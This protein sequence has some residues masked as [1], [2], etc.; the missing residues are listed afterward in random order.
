M[1]HRPDGGGQG[2]HSLSIDGVSVSAPATVATV[3]EPSLAFELYELKRKIERKDLEIK[4]KDK[5][6][7]GCNK[8]L[9]R[10]NKELKHSAAELES[11]RDR[12]EQLQ[13]SLITQKLQ[14]Q[15]SKD[16]GEV[17]H[18]QTRLRDLE[19]AVSSAVHKHNMS[20][21]ELEASKKATL[22]VEQKLS[23]CMNALDALSSS[24]EQLKIEVASCNEALQSATS[25]AA[26]LESQLSALDNKLQ[27]SENERQRFFHENSSLQSERTACNKQ[28]AELKKEVRQLTANLTIRTETNDS[29]QASID[30][31]HG[32]KQFLSKADIE[33]YKKMEIENGAL[34]ERINEMV[35]SVDLHLN[36]LSKSDLEIN[37]LRVELQGFQQV[38]HELRKSA[39]TL[40]EQLSK[41]NEYTDE[42]RRTLTKTERECEEL[43]EHLRNK[44]IG[45]DKDVNSL[46]ASIVALV[47]AKQQEFDLKLQE[48][49]K[50]RTVE[51]T[52]K[53]LKSRIVFLLEQLQVAAKIASTWTEQQQVL[54][55]QCQALTRVN[56]TLRQQILCLK[57][58]QHPSL[59][60]KFLANTEGYD[61]LGKIDGSN[62]D[63]SFFLT[64]LSNISNP[65]S[66]AVNNLSAAATQDSTFISDIQPVGVVERSIF[67][68]TVAF[69]ASGTGSH[70]LQRFSFGGKRR[71]AGL[72]RKTDLA[73]FK[74][75]A[76]EDGHIDVDTIE[77][78][79]KMEAMEL[80][81][82]LQVSS[83]MKFVQVST[84]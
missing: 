39:A 29:L 72:S 37:R 15:K 49:R 18:M 43:V 63:T 40:T 28:V 79:G 12:N 21:G 42:L 16:E 26:M 38:N 30:E 55:S 2:R 81:A 69:G 7:L 71:K 65:D 74:T 56:T 41:S 77:G 24:N 11:L 33:K 53:G 62:N 25:K 70:G 80:L 19:S 13:Q 10:V 84:L 83:F 57:Q 48:M 50:R 8:E 36:L 59:N 76:C 22:L 68:A 75:K 46:K 14:I 78:V 45:M 66:S 4:R 44:G 67:D 35:N 47:K 32:N 9:S 1:A 34:Q 31:L 82:N 23:N 27:T 20:E 60:S 61:A 5:E 52:V 3:T 17:K 73:L 58:Q 54:Q 51:S 6:I 64:N